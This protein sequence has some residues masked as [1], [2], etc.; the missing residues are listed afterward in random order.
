MNSSFFSCKFQIWIVEL[1]EPLARNLASEEKLTELIDPEC[2]FIVAVRLFVKFHRTIYPFSKP[3][4]RNFP[5]GQ[6]TIDFTLESF[7]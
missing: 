1:S 4:A 3:P 5:F 6:N 2:A 7:I